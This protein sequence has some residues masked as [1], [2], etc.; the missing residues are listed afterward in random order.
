MIYYLKFLLLDSP[1]FCP[2]KD[3][4][5]LGVGTMSYSWL[6]SRTW[7]ST[8]CGYSV[9]IW[10]RKRTYRERRKHFFFKEVVRAKWMM[11][12]CSNITVRES[13]AIL[14]DGSQSFQEGISWAAEHHMIDSRV[15]GLKVKQFGTAEAR[16]VLRGLPCACF[17]FFPCCSMCLECTLWQSLP[18]LSH[19]LLGLLIFQS[20]TQMPL[21]FLGTVSLDT[22][23]S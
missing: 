5:A 3:C 11:L 14:L 8:W 13:M 12:K 16:N 22:I 2:S 18:C 21:T 17:F 23:S 20:L 9:N 7:Q 15:Q 6:F 10:W 4:E 1:A 19:L